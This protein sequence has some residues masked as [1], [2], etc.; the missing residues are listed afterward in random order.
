[1]NSQVLPK[2]TLV[3]EGFANLHQ[4]FIT[5]GGK[6]RLTNTRLVF[7]AHRIRQQGG[8]TEIALANITS[9]ETAWTRLLGVVPILPTSILVSTRD[10]KYYRFVVHGRGRWVTAINAQRNK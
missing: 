10:G 7:E 3:K 9:T 6:L 1:M 5:L 2:E 8:V 4:N